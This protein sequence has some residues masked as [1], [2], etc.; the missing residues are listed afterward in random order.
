MMKTLE[1]VTGNIRT[2][3]SAIT[4]DLERQEVER[5][6]LWKRLQAARAEGDQLRA[7]AQRSTDEDLSASSAAS[8][9][10]AIATIDEAPEEDA[11][12]TPTT[13]I[14]EAP[15]IAELLTVVSP[16]RQEL[17]SPERPPPPQAV[18]ASSRFGRGGRGRHRSLPA[19]PPSETVLEGFVCP[20][21]FMR[22]PTQEVLQSHW[23]AVHQ[24]NSDRFFDGARA[25]FR[26]VKRSMSQRPASS[27]ATAAAPPPPQ[28]RKA[29]VARRHT[30]EME[31][32]KWR[33]H[34]L[35]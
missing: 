24:T 8:S 22:A 12:T 17:G 5:E 1:E 25:A 30:W 15:T 3:N 10:R 33:Q 28:I 31:L 23:E 18:P 16:E 29:A 14:E 11:P 9:P 32:V 6:N 34:A 13:P 20:A 19:A 35:V 4:E 27:R 7:L 21:C 2:G 26:R